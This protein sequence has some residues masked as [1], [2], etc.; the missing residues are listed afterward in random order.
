MRN[1]LMIAG[2]LTALVGAGLPQVLSAAD[3]PKNMSAEEL[4]KA[5]VSATI[6]LDVKQIGLILG[7][8]RGEGILHYQGK[9]Y[10][11]TLKG[12]QIGAI[13]GA[14]RS[15]ATGDVRF[16]NRLE[17][18]PGSYS[19]VGA[20]VAVGAGGDKSSF[21]NNKGVVFS[22]KQK[23]TGLALDLG[24]TAGEVSFKK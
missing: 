16:L 21:Q 11:F 20:G 5:P 10:P 14:T 13:I 9:N 7:G 17:D 15:S 12:L 8:Q 4:R 3:A 6:E 19:A 23:T 2:V 18:F 22:L 24:I 1:K